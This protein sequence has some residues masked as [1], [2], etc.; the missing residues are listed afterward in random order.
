MSIIERNIKLFPCRKNENMRRQFRF[1]QKKL[2][3]MYIEKYKLKPIKKSD[4]IVP[5]KRSSYEV[6]IKNMYRNFSIIL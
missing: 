4:N 6:I 2:C 5:M 1:V 3:E